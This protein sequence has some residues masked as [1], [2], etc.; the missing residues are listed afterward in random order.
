MR[1]PALR[2]A[3]L[4]SVASLTSVANAEELP[5]VEVE[6]GAQKTIGPGAAPNCDDP[7]VAW[8]SADRAGVL[9]G[10][11]VGSTVCSMMQD[12]GAR[13]VFRIEVV[14]AKKKDGAGGTKGGGP[15][16]G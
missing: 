11:K 4:L 6:V 16:A 1:S 13:R 14:P 7:S 5:V 8:I 12:G 2:L 9:H 15:T 10:V 3:L